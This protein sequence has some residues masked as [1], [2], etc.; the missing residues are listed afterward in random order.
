MIYDFRV[1]QSFDLKSW[2]FCVRFRMT[3]ASAGE[4]LCVW[5]AASSGWRAVCP[6]RYVA[7]SP[8][9]TAFSQ[10][11]ADTSQRLLGAGPP[12]PVLS[13]S[14]PRGSWSAQCPRSSL[15]RPRQSMSP[16]LEASSSS[17]SRGGGASLTHVGCSVTRRGRDLPPA[18]FTLPAPQLLT[19]CGSSLNVG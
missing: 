8:W 15:P 5:V 7:S 2:S 4:S 14:F 10:P 3:S 16:C 6:G 12:P 18:S 1:L 13:L 9:L 17:W 11:A 19:W